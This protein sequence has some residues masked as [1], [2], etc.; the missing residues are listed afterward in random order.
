MKLADPI[1]YTLA[2]LGIKSRL[3]SLER[4]HRPL[5]PEELGQYKTS[6]FTPVE[7]WEFR[8]NT[9]GTPLFFVGL[10]DGFFPFSP[11]R[12]VTARDLALQYP[13]VGADGVICLLAP[14]DIYIPKGDGGG[15][16]NL[17]DQADSA[18]LA[19]A[20]G[21]NPTDFHEEF[22]SYWSVFCGARFHRLK[23][24]YSILDLS[25]PCIQSIFYHQRKSTVVFSGTEEEGRE[26]LMNLLGIE[27][28][29]EFDKGLQGG[30]TCLV[31]LSAPLHPREFPRTG[32]EI[33]KLAL[34]AAGD[35]ADQLREY[36]LKIPPCRNETNLPI[37][38]GF[39]GADGPVLA[40]L[41]ALEPW[42]FD[43]IGAKGQLYHSRPRPNRIACRGGEYR[44]TVGRL[45]YNP[46]IPVEPFNVTRADPAWIHFRGGRGDAFDLA[47]LSVAIIG[48]GS[49]GSRLAEQLARNGVGRLILYD[50]ESLSVGNVGRHLLGMKY[51][52][53][54]KVTALAG[55]LKRSFPHLKVDAFPTDWRSARVD[56]EAWKRLQSQELIISLTGDMTSDMTLNYFARQESMF[57]AVIYGRTEA[58]GCAGHAVLID[59]GPC[60]QC[61]IGSDGNFL[62]HAVYW[63]K[64]PLK[65]APACGEVF[66]PYGSVETGPIVSMI[67]RLALDHLM[68]RL[69]HSSAYRVWLAHES[70]VRESGGSWDENWVRQHG[71]PGEGERGLRLT[72]ERTSGCPVCG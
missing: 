43:G 67:A 14:N 50:G 10:I 62:D 8:L 55:Y 30:G 6:S 5:K 2:V 16:I 11:P 54:E 64:S 41:H 57:P 46:S 47:S 56:K 60:L 29:R 45:F 23:Y 21:A 51:V 48:C 7:G 13:H 40:G 49:L 69:D 68:G 26:W 44:S 24:A 28:E 25:A 12:F 4:W 32:G 52:D 33:F 71:D 39:E 31:W 63:P 17:L 61:G 18:L 65:K 22:L 34:Q 37:L 70:L 38:F 35:S 36:L 9:P 42:R 19:G 66:A 58:Y 59:G 20:S 53:R 1:R 27:K 72:W 15:F 3:S